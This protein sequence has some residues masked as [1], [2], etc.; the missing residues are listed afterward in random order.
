MSSSDKTE[1]NIPVTLSLTAGQHDKLHTHLFPGD[2]LEAVAIAL[3][4]RRAG[5]NRHRLMV[6]EIY[7]IPYKDCQR[8]PVSVKWETD[9]V[10]PI[11]DQAEAERLSVVKIHGHPAGHTAF[12]STDETSDGLLF[13][14]L[15][16]YI[17]HDIPHGS[18]VMLPNGQMFGRVLWNGHAYKPIVSFTVTGPDLKFWYSHPI[19]ATASDF[20]ASHVQAFGEGTFEQF[21]RLSIAVVGCS[22]TGSLVTEQLA[23]LG[24]GHLVLIDDDIVETRNL[25]RILQAT[26]KDV[27]LGRLKVDVVGDAIRRAGLGTDVITIPRNLWDRE[28]V[29]AAA[30]CDILFGCMDTSEGRFLLNKLA[31]W[32]TLPYFD[33]GVRLVAVP[34]GPQHGYI[35]EVCGTVHYLQ[36]GGSSLMSRGL[37]TMEQVKA[38]GLRRTDPN[39]YQRD[40]EDGYIR[41]VHVQ[42][43]AVISLNSF[44][45]GLAVQDFLA[46]LHPYREG[47]NRDI[48][49]IEFSLS[50][51]EFFPEPEG[52]PCSMLMHDVGKGDQEPLL[53]LLALAMRRS[54]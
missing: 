32:Y 48:A 30:E 38:D 42:R 37:V 47:P 36:P 40:L 35:R 8:T 1:F 6:R 51:L 11:F 9:R 25:N 15:R 2:G 41:G 27:R 20:A 26:T 43:P 50:S 54:E 23:R 52:D 4:N 7:P 22:G 34:D 29:L 16:G 12:S 10:T 45:T 28:A 49:L 5:T 14:A 39:A 46:R 21:Q 53:G 33:L 17:E 24:V 18:A 13:P 19:T 31:T 3:C 44:I